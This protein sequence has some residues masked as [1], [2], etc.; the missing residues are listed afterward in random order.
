MMRTTAGYPSLSVSFFC[1]DAATAAGTTAGTAGATNAG[2][3][4][5]VLRLVCAGNCSG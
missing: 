3:K 1:A 4:D 5:Y 2:D